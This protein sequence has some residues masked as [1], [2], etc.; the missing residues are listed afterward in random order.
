[1]V[2]ARGQTG[3][4]C[5]VVGIGG[6]W[7]AMVDIQATGTRHVVNENEML[8]RIR[9]LW[10]AETK[11]ISISG[12]SDSKQYQDTLELVTR[13]STAV[14]APG[15]AARIQGRAGWSGH[16]PALKQKISSSHVYRDG[17]IRVM[18]RARIAQRGVPGAKD[19]SNG[20]RS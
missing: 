10:D 4:S 9:V 13:S 16:F 7:V 11:H 17:S 5:P 3:R 8:H 19:T 6:G 14:S 12:W 1:M 18:L 15:A 2:L 20:R